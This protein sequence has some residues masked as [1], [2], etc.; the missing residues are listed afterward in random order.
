MNHK[1]RFVNRF[2]LFVFFIFI[3][4]FSFHLSAKLVS[5]ERATTIA[6]SFWNRQKTRSVAGS[7]R[8]SWDNRSLS[9]ATRSSEANDALF[10]V[11]EG[12]AGKGF[13]IVSADDQ[14]MP[15][16]GYSFESAAPKPNNLPL[17]MKDWIGGISE[18]I[19]YIKDNQIE[20][21]N[22]AP[23]WAKAV[24]G[25]VVV[26]LETALWNQREPYNNQCPYDQG[27]RSLTGC[28]PTAVAIVMKYYEW[29][30]Y[31]GGKTESYYTERK[32]IFVES[33]DLYHPY[34]WN[35]M[36]MIYDEGFSYEEADE[37]STLMADIGAAF[38]VDYANNETWGFVDVDA[39]K[40]HFRY[41]PEMYISL[42]AEYSNTAWLQM[43]KRELDYLRPI[44]YRGE[45]T[46]SSQYAHIF[47][48]DGYTDDEYFHINWGWGGFCNGYYTLSTLAP[49]DK[50]NFNAGQWACFNVEPMAINTEDWLKI[51][52]PGIVVSETEFVQNTPFIINE[53]NFIY[54]TT[55][56]FSGFIRA[57]IT[58]REGKIK[59]WI[60]EEFAFSLGNSENKMQRTTIGIAANATIKEAITF[61]DRIRFFYRYQNSDEWD[62]IKSSNEVGC[63]W[64]I[65]VADEYSISES[66]SFTF[67]KIDKTITLKIK[68]GV[69][70]ELFSSTQESI[71]NGLEVNG[72]TVVIHTYIFPKDTY[73][74][75]LQKGSDVKTLEFAV[76]SI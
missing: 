53:V 61:G 6:E 14:V 23:M 25:N 17:P 67:N 8:F 24:A 34:H 21:H 39:L 50:G 28:V 71:T 38:K 58:D 57:A 36:P 31:G 26:E 18:Q 7:V 29:P 70:V 20:N 72:N 60:T 46:Y 16:L 55:E 59:E 10:Y 2:T 47:V 64:E 32:G 19:Q 75:K 5:V 52:A 11:F 44:L 62:L 76:K 63:Q 49:D 1:M 3:S 48:L 54:C 51:S 9:N 45:D 37:V 42:R 43:L 74:I 30:N 22:A 73:T 15:I 33:R 56:D 66:T 40:E 12:T 13:V 68:D 27:I 41:S 65:L 4:F 35:K 69:S